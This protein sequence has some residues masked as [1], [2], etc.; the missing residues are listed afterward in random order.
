MLRLILFILLVPSLCL[1]QTIDL[2]K[3][4]Q[5]ARMNPYVAGGGVAAS[6]TA[7][8]CTG[9]LLFSWH[10]ENAD[11]TLDSSGGTATCPLGCSA[12]DTTATATSSATLSTAQYQDGGYSCSF[13][14]AG[15]YYSF[16]ISSEDIA[17]SAEG[18][19]ILYIYV[20]TYA[21]GS[22]VF[23][24]YYDA[25]NRVRITMQTSTY[26][27]FKLDH[28]AASTTRS[29]WTLNTSNFALNTWLKITAK[30]KKGGQGGV[31]QY[32]SINDTDAGTQTSSD[33]GDFASPPTSLRIG[34]MQGNSS[35]YYIDNV[36]IYST[37]Q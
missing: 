21:S 34:E 15:D 14:T 24:I 31:Y 17:K 4:M 20:S 29:V 5:I 32:I 26:Y 27:K 18:T 1:A 30:W 8:S 2:S 6:C 36:K 25:N 13:P 3:P 12:G 22:G 7:D 37:W 33:F 9:G 11:V 35:A 19:V 16:T 10:C 23:D 28:V